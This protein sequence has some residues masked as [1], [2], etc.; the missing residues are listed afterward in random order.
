VYL[1]E[2]NKVVSSVV[3]ITRFGEY[4]SVTLMK[5]V[6]K[7]FIINAKTRGVFNHL[8]PNGHYSGRTAPLTYRCCIFYLFNKYTY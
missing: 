1:Q 8:T 4:L 3:V 5:C 2:E 6:N 7:H